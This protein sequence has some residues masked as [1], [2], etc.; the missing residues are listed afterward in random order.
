MKKNIAI[1]F[2][3]INLD[4]GKSA[5]RWGKWR[6]TVDLCRQDD[7]VITRYEILCD[8][9]YAA[10][11]ETV[12][13][14]IQITS[15]ETEVIINEMYIQNPWDLEEVYEVLFDFV[16]LYNFDTD[17]EEYL[18][19]ITT[20]THVTQICMFLLNESRFLPG[21]ILQL[22][23]PRRKDR[24][25]PGTYDIIDL[26]LS[27]YDNIADRFR[28]A[29]EQDT[30]FL[31]AGIPTR[32][33][34]FNTMIE[35]IEQ[36]AIRTTNPVL[37]S[38][39]TGT[40]KGNLARRIYELKKRRHQIE[41]EFV[42]INCATLK[43]EMAMSSLFGHKRGAYAGATKDREGLLKAAHKGVVFL[44][45]IEALGPDE[46]AMI[47]GALEDKAFYPL[48]GDKVE[49][50][51]FQLIAG[52]AEDLAERVADGSFRADLL[53]RINMWSY[54][55]PSLA[56]RK[57]DIAPNIDFELIKFGE[58]QNQKIAFNKE[59]R[60]AYLN[61]ALSS[62]AL[63]SA[64]FRDLTA[65]ITR[66]CTFAGGRRISTELVNREIERLRRSWRLASSDPEDKIL[67]S[68]LTR[69]RIEQIDPFDRPGLANAIKICRASD[70]LSD[71]G[72]KLFAVSRA[73]RKSTNDSDR[74]KK[75]LAKYDLSWG[76]L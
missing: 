7:L 35:E 39:P 3:G 37:L 52:T 60:T 19:N 12:A 54:R 65:S 45:E 20:G 73:Q 48:G 43:G 5:E 32:N 71:A 17:N 59:A 21:R 61:F 9:K 57:E 76:E 42:S 64:N 36:V 8:P 24:G 27:K 34:A 28:S 75:Y 74:L 16:D 10:L 14:D 29:K 55:L 49:R 51:D 44:D 4:S 33:P 22:S 46:Q 2:L 69:N 56:E 70:N 68:V 11:A 15:P 38:G 62:E 40:G 63:W 66:L 53:A 30:A 31:K 26:D 47:L 58:R 18:L 13:R 23:P 6:P 72:R 1:G 25:G 67:L 50:S 41:G